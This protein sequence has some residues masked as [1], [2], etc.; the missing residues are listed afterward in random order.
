ME[1][2]VGIDFIIEELKVSFPQTSAK[3]E[4]SQTVQT[5]PPKR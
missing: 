5:I 2:Q 3:I 1:S 4:F